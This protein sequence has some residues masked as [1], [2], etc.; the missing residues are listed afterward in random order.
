MTIAKQKADGEQIEN[1]LKTG[2][3]G[4]AAAV[5]VVLLEAGLALSPK[6]LVLKS[7]LHR[8]YVYDALEE[9]LEK[10]LTVRVGEGRRVRYQATSPQ[11]LLQEAEKRRLDVFEG[12]RDLM[13]LYERSPGGMITVIEGNENVIDD[14][15]QILLDTKEGDFLD[16]IGG[17]G[18]KW[19]ALFEG[20]LEEFEALRKKKNLNIR[21]IGT[22]ADVQHNRERSVIRSD[23]RIISGIGDLVTVSIRPDSV[24]FN[25]YEPQALIV[26]VKNVAAVASQRALFEV[27]WQVAR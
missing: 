15:F 14:E 16:V 5:Y 12:V 2:L 25:F 23:S 19:E 4:K 3:S 26:R 9:L 20:R 1:A 22:E 24:S 18:G 27:L 6:T 7:G 13:R 10:R 8:Q 11:R 17:G 21:Y